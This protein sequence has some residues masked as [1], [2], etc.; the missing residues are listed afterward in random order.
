MPNPIKSSLNQSFVLIK[1]HKRI[2]VGLLLLQIIFLSI[3]IGLQVY[4]Q[5]QALASAQE[6]MDYLQE[7]DLGDIAVAKNIIKGSSILGENA[8]II[9]RNYQVIRSLMLRLGL[10][11]LLAYLVFGSLMWALTDQLI[12]KKNKKKFIKYLGKFLLLALGFIAV[13][14]VL[15]F[16]GLRGILAAYFTELS[17]N[18]GD[19]VYL[20]LGLIFTHFMFVSF[21]LISKV[22]L[23]D[24]LKT[25][26]DLGAK[27]AHII[28][29]AYLINTVILFVLIQLVHALSQRNM[30][31]LGIGLI[32]MIFS[33]VWTRIFLFLTVNKLKG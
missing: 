30:V 6:V 32:L 31:I 27:K 3:I 16:S 25:A 29:I 19:F 10:Y 23:K 9:A 1:K 11:S 14:F 4:Y 7:Q 13:I 20:I 26:F 22:K 12:H 5:V 33:F 24:L 18:P 28:L 15:L 2:F 21:S 17:L 8:E